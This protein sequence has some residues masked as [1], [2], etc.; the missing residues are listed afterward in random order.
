MCQPP[1]ATAD[2]GASTRHLVDVLRSGYTRVSSEHTGAWGCAKYLPDVHATHEAAE[3][4]PE[5][6]TMLSP[7]CTHL[8]VVL[9]RYWFT[10]HLVVTHEAW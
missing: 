2:V 6:A 8:P 7:H 10:W 4:A 1:S 9:S 5:A 3:V